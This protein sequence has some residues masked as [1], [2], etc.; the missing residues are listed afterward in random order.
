MSRRNYGVG[1]G[2]PTVFMMIIVLTMCV[3]SV[4]SYQN[5]INNQK[6][7]D[8]EIEYTVDYYRARAKADKML[9]DTNEDISVKIELNNG[10]Y[11][12]VIRSEGKIIEYCIRR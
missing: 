1:M 12:S 2:I 3:M 7:V 10:A 6:T 11:L 9:E 5:A 8:R 4:L